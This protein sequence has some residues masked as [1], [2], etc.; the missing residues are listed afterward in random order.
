M[1][2]FKYNPPPHLTRFR[3]ENIYH[4]TPYGALFAGNNLRVY[5][6]YN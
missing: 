6:P 4:D 2:S 3:H 5:V 1:G